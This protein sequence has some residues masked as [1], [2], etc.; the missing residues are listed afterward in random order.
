M[1]TILS[2]TFFCEFSM[3]YVVSTIAVC[4]FLLATNAA[5]DD[6]SKKDLDSL[7]GVWQCVSID[8]AKKDN[9][10]EDFVKKVRLTFKGTTGTFTFPDRTEEF[11][12][13]LD[14]AKKPKAIDLAIQTGGEKGKTIPS[15]YALDGDS[16]KLCAPNKGGI[17]RPT[18]FKAG[19]QVAIITFKRAKN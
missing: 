9:P 8:F 3:R 7:Q 18:D 17:E 12:I 13:K 6:P 11:T 16:L 14:A 10:P 15:I 19:E 1:L 2:R 5:Q 4:C